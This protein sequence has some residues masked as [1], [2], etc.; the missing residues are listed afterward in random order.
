LEDKLQEAL[1]DL[2]QKSKLVAYLQSVMQP[3]QMQ[4]LPRPAP[5]LLSSESD[6]ISVCFFLFLLVNN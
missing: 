2:E 6:Y 4:K 5:S 1:S 3:K